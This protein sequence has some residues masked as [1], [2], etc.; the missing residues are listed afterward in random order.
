VTLDDW[1]KN[2]QIAQS[3]ALAIAVLGGGGWALFQFLS[4]HSI[5]KARADLE[6]ARRALRQ[7]GL[8]NMSLDYKAIAEPAKSE[9]CLVCTVGI[10]NVGNRTEVLNW[11]E[12]RLTARGLDPSGLPSAGGQL[13]MGVGPRELGD[14]I[15]S[16]IAP[17]EKHRMVFALSVP[18]PGLYFLDFRAVGTAVQAAEAADEARAVAGDPA[19]EEMVWGAQTIAVVK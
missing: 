4:L 18:G 17:S 19:I 14:L 7:R 1:V 3:L 9:R 12:S 2:A 8:L 6:A 15:Y 11:Q 5:A 10:R 16:S 13:I